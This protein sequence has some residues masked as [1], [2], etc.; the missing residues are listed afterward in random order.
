MEF[1]DGDFRNSLLMRLKV[2]TTLQDLNLI[3]TELEWLDKKVTSAK[4]KAIITV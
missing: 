2:L 4:E 3:N 1:K